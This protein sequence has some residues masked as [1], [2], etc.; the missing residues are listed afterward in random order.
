MAI[1]KHRVMDKC[2]KD[3]KP[4]CFSKECFE[5]EEP[6]PMTNGDKIRAM[7]DE[8]LAEFIH[9][10]SHKCQ[11]TCYGGCMRCKYTWCNYV[12]TEEWLKQPAEDDC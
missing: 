2:K 11:E 6:K 1:C 9:D 10:V 4:C 3:G 7:T 8:E 5:P 12:D